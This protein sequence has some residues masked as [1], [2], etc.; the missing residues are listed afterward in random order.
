VKRRNYS[1]GEDK[2]E[3]EKV[4]SEWMNKTW[5]YFDSNKEPCS[6]NICCGYV[7]FSYNT[8]MKY[9]GG[10]SETRHTLG[11]VVGTQCFMKSKDHKFLIDAMARK[12]RADEGLTMSE[13][14]DLVKEVLSHL[15][16]I[17]AQ[18]SFVRTVQGNHKSAEEQIGPRSRHNN[19]ADQDHHPSAVPMDVHIR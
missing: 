11:C 8:M 5:R 16:R 1:K 9:V 4:V 14:I 15:S 18:R 7:G 10:N 17:Q 12:D 2:I 19:K 13:S 3:L 6:L